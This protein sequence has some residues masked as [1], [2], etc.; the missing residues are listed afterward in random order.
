MA[1]AAF[2]KERFPNVPLITGGY[3]ATALPDEVVFEG[4]PFDAVLLGEGERPLVQIVQGVYWAV[5]RSNNN[6]MVLIWCRNLDDLPSYAWDLLDRY[7]PR[8]KDLGAKFQVY[9]SRGCPYHCT[10][11]MERSKSGYQW[12]A[13]S[14]ERA[15]DELR[16]LAARTDLSHWVVNLA[17]PLFGFR[18]KWRRQVLEG[19]IEHQFCF[20]GST[21]P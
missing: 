15:V 6:A 16:R 3:H 20:H 5:E 11:C 19:I 7:W 9:L 2:L 12:R 21:G 8:A 14:A 10:F 13:Y 17:D 1:L 18:R 4:S